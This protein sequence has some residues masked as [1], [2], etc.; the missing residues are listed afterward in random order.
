[1]NNFL[2]I[3]WYRV[4]P[5][6]YGGQKGIAHFNY[7][8]GRKVMLTCLCSRNNTVAEE[9]SYKLVNTLPASRLQFWNPFVRNRILS[10]IRRQHFS[11]IIIEHPWHG[12]L[13]VHKKKYGFKFII[14]AHNI[15]HLRIKARN[16]FWW[17]SLKNTEETSFALAD[18]ILFKTEEDKQTAMKLFNVSPQ[19]CLIIPYGVTENKPPFANRELIDRIRTQHHVNTAEK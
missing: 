12:W 10:L 11:H 9:L 16:K 19:K 15:E 3:V 4:L 5:P 13:G 14:H 2:S 17:R 18:F 1:M 7:Y 6:E 8:L